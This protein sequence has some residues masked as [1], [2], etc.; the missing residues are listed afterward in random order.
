MRFHVLGLAHLPTRREISPCAYT[1]KIVNLCKMLRHEGHE[2]FFYGVENSEVLATESVVVLST[3]DWEAQFGKYDWKKDQFNTGEGKGPAWDK[4][5]ANAI[6]EVQRRLKPHDFVLCPMGTWHKPIVDKLRGKFLAA[7]S[8]IG[9]TG[10]FSKYR[11]FESY[12][13]MHHVYGLRKITDGQFYDTVIPNY[14]D[15]KDFAYSEEKDDY[16]LFIG[17]LVKRKG[18]DVAVEATRVAD[19]KL[20]IAGQRTPETRDS[21]LK[22]PHV[23]FVGTVGPEERA[24]LMSKARCVLVPTYYLEP[25]GGVNVETCLCGTPVITTDWG[26]F[27][28]TVLQGVTG[29][30]CSTL[31][32]FV[33][34]I[35]NTQYIKPKACRDWAVNNFSIGVIGQR[36]HH[37]FRRLH[38]LWGKGWYSLRDTDLRARKIELPGPRY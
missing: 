1:Q 10:I 19:R 38:D 24:K 25:F 20:I 14:Y 4:F 12:A 21:W 17:R 13:W 26:A 32:E 23:E 6:S 36:Y 8:G 31:G 5:R 37:Y 29:Y 18:I 16:C 33:W 7:E 3:K 22:A 15:P 35:N 30:R 34:A 28:E 27:S 2:V 11:V 9:Y